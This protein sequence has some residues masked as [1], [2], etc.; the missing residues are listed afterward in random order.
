MSDLIDSFFI[1][2]GLSDECKREVLNAYNEDWRAYHNLKHIEGMLKGL[3][4]YDSEL[5]WQDKLP[6]RLL[7]EAAIVYHDVVYKVGDTDNEIK[8][9]RLFRV[10]CE[11]SFHSQFFEQNE[12]IYQVQKL[13]LATKK[14]DYNSIGI[15]RLEQIIIELD[16]SG[17]DGEFVNVLTIEDKV[18][19][20]FTNNGQS[21]MKDYYKK[22]LDFLYLYQSK[23]PATSAQINIKYLM[24]VIKYRLN[25]L[26]DAKNNNLSIN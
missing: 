15:S 3:S 21:D 16:L 7:L 14:H 2:S 26:L 4:K 6:Q 11:N 8:S 9:A 10:H 18:C 23:V 20:E 19:K 22:K 17:F 1:K 13:I 24:G 25:K 12:L 5:D